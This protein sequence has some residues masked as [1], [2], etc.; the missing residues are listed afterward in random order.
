M[1]TF[2][3]FFHSVC[4]PL[5]AALALTISNAFAAENG[6]LQYVNGY[7]VAPG[8]ILI[9]IAPNAANAVYPQ[10]NNLGLTSKHKFHLIRAEFWTFP[11]Q[12]SVAQTLASVSQIA[13]VKAVCPDYVLTF[14]QNVVTPNDLN[15]DKQYA[16]PMM[17]LP[18]AWYLTTGSSDVIVAVIDSGIQ[19][20]VNEQTEEYFFHPDHE[21]NIYVNTSETPF[22]EI[23]NDA[24]GYVDDVHGWDFPD[25]DPYTSDDSTGH[26]TMVAGVLGATGNNSEGI[27]GVAWN[28]KIL[29][30]KVRGD[31]PG[32]LLTVILEAVEYAVDQGASVVN[33]SWGGPG[34]IHL[35]AEAVQ[36]LQEAG[37]IFV[38][39]AGN[40]NQD[41]DVTPI[42]PSALNLANILSVAATDSADSLAH[43]PVSSSNYGL[44]SVDL[45]APGVDTLTTEVGS[46][47]W[48]H[49]GTSFAAPHVSGIAA[50]LKSK[51]PS[52]GVREMR[53]MIMEG[54]DP[55]P[56]L[57]GK[58]V[59]S[60]RAN[61][62]RTL[63][64][65]V[66]E[67][68]SYDDEPGS[69]IAIPDNDANGITRTITVN[70]SVFVRA[71]SVSVTLDHDRMED[72]EITLES[73]D[74]TVC[75][76][77][78]PSESTGEGFEGEWSG[79]YVLDTRWAF[80]GKD[81]DGNWELT[82]K[83]LIEN[84]EGTLVSWELEIH[85]YRDDENTNLGGGILCINSSD[86][87]VK[88]SIL[89][90][91]T[92]PANS[93]PQIAVASADHPST[94]TVSY[95]DVEGGE[96]DVFVDTDCTLTWS[97]GN[98]DE[99]PLFYDDANGDYHLKSKY[100]RWDPVSEDWEEDLVSSPCDAGDP[101]DEYPNEPE[102]AGF[103]INMG[104][105]GNTPVASKFKWYLDADATGDCRVNI[106]DMIFVRNRM[107]KEVSSG[108]NWKADLTGNGTINILDLIAVRNNLNN[109]CE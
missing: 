77:A 11:S 37:V 6:N 85:T 90:D 107:Y 55:V 49:N 45:A 1:R 104:A 9:T 14:Y 66:P 29:P 8:R 97:D 91:N 33:A 28:V 96:N 4:P 84:N 42:Y 52:I 93:G 82:V 99:D 106:L 48:A 78:S 21:D 95:S 69:P 101:A 50:L 46:S 7:P 88:N 51:Y 16:L 58:C 31:D 18:E 75:E 62:Y 56:S 2:G 41:I 23:D 79:A 30:L 98:M 60:G 73:P 26:G 47:Y 57:S 89:W 32:A 10:L 74:E 44:E 65:P 27:T 71:V 38:A 103:R 83:D 80:R 87:D 36:V 39:A 105:Y 40:S 92:S 13:G 100:G 3:N 94:V 102:P 61:A 35:L 22:D 67:T 34:H 54:T 12:N 19:L 20:D 15:Y 109:R 24:N 76:L 64:V 53:V 81:S 43:F 5:A 72:M 59:T 25:E 108:D 86:V 68:L 63:T 70:D 17:H